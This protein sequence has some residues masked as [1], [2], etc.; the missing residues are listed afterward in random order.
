[1]KT[2]TEKQNIFCVCDYV[3][4]SR[5][6]C[7]GGGDFCQWNSLDAIDS[8]ASFYEDYINSSNKYIV[9]M[10]NYILFVNPKVDA[11]HATANAVL[12]IVS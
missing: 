2:K 7:H 9:Y 4:V 1:M 5:Y 6:F 11:L 8:H 10:V 3:A 12:F